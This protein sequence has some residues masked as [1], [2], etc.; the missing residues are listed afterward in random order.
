M[1]Q[2]TLKTNLTNPNNQNLWHPKLPPTTKNYAPQNSHHLTSHLT[3]VKQRLLPITEDKINQQLKNNQ[4]EI[5][6]IVF[7]IRL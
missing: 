1:D 4:E 6:V 3:F 2:I 7:K 5:W